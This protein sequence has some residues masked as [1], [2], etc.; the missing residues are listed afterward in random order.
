VIHA[1]GKYIL[2]G[3]ID[4]HN[5][6]SAGFDA[7]FGTY[8]LGTGQF[9]SSERAYK[10]GLEKALK[11]YLK[12]GVTKVVLTSMAAPLDQLKDSFGH[13]KDFLQRDGYLS[14]LVYGINLEGTF[15]K[16]PVYAGAQNPKYF[17]DVDEKVVNSLQVASGGSLRIVN[18]PPEHGEKGYKLTRK[19]KDLGIV[20]A[21]GHSAAYGDEYKKAIG[22]GLNLAVHF[23]N[24][25]S[26]SNSKSFRS[27][28]AVEAM[29]RSDRVFLEIIC[30]GYHVDPSYVRDVIARKGFERV[31]MITDSMFANGMAHLEQFELFGLQGAVHK[32][33]EYLQ[34]LG[35]ENT[36]FGSVLNSNVG[37]SNVILWLTQEMEGTWHRT[38]KALPLNDALLQASAMFS[39]NPAKL[40]GIFDSGKGQKGTGS[41]EVGK[42][43]D[44][45]VADLKADKLSISHN[46]LKGTVHETKNL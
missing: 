44:L 19:L 10:N 30:D 26:R 33:R 20:V 22:E 34:V 25:P 15:L 32:S 12:A 4:V 9:D 28:G 43:A 45:I 1:S 16:D 40:L 29:L 14:E 17:F 6:G 11:S 35:S 2:P 3:F 37:F 23:L 46:L 8:D 42:S 36:L 41:V 24:G 27:G 38:H 21:G 7:S 39:S 13:L 5:H 31:I 18:I